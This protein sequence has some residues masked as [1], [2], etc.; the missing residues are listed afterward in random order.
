M[1]RSRVMQQSHSAQAHRPKRTLQKHVILASKYLHDDMQPVLEWWTNVGGLHLR[2]EP[3][4]L[5]ETV[6]LFHRWVAMA[7]RSSGQGVS[8]CCCCLTG[9]LCLSLQRFRAR[10]YLLFQSTLQIEL[11]GIPEGWS[12]AMIPGLAGN[13]KL[14]GQVVLSRKETGRR[15]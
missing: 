6:R 8:S 15:I 7:P 14:G 1:A 5:T 2:L 3:E 4:D 11:D 12:S 13:V 9:A 10:E